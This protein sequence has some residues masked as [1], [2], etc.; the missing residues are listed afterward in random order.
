MVESVKAASDIYSP[1]AGTVES[2]NEALV[3][4]PALINT[5]PYGNGWIFKLR[6]DSTSSPSSLKTPEEYSELLGQ[7]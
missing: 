2:V 4:D 6:L 3:S 1:A 7:L 5:D